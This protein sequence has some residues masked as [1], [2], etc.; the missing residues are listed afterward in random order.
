MYYLP[1]GSD[2]FACVGPAAVSGLS[3]SNFVPRENSSVKN[4][5]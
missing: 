2:L 3:L 4:R 1:P 5:V